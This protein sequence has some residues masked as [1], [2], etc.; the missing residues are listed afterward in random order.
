MNSFSAPNSKHSVVSPQW[1]QTFVVIILFYPL[2]ISVDCGSYAVPIIRSLVMIDIECFFC[3]LIG[4]S[5]YTQ[6]VKKTLEKVIGII[7][8]IVIEI[9]DC[10]ALSVIYA[11][12]EVV[13][14]VNIIKGEVGHIGVGVDYCE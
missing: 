2:K 12:N 11:I 1:G 6:T 8:D 14:T 5:S 10:V 7:V 4:L 9:Y 3:N 13:I